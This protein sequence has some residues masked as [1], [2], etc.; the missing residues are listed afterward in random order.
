MN[1]RYEWTPTV[2]IGPILLGAP[3]QQYVDAGI[4][5]PDPIPE[6]LGGGVS[7]IDDVDSITV[8]PDES[9]DLL[10]ESIQCDRSIL[11]RGVELLGKS[12]D[13]IVEVLGSQPDEF[14]DEVELYDGDVQIIAEFDDLGLLIWMK[15]GVSAVA[16][17]GPANYDE[18]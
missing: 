3:I 13:E 7:F 6:E 15:E 1:T 16:A 9:A 18:D 4:L 2:G 11:Y 14:S 10:I 8:T 17:F 12:I 5:K